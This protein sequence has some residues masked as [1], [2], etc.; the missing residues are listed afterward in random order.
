MSAELPASGQK[1]QAEP[2]MPELSVAE[3]R[4]DQAHLSRGHEEQ[5]VRSNWQVGDKIQNSLEIHK[6]LKGGLGIVY[7][8]HEPRSRVTLAAKTFQD[9]VFASDPR[10]REL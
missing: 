5:R 2:G 8:L 6:I 9:E 3:P 4:P 1:N 7:V 10:V